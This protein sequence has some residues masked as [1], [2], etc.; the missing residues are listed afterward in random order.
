MAVVI[1]VSCSLHVTSFIT[2]THTHTF[3]SQSHS[4]KVSPV[5]YC[6]CNNRHTYG[7]FINDVTLD[8]GEESPGLSDDV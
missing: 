5:I 6:V 1:E 2:H 7:T 4:A 8:K 3:H